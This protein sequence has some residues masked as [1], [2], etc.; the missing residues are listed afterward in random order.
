M[1]APAITVS[2]I[3]H[4]VVYVADVARSVAF[5][6]GVLGM[7]VRHQGKGYAFLH[8]G[9]A[10]QQIGLFEAEDGGPPTDADLNHLAFSVAAGDYAGLKG[11]LEASGVEVRGRR[12][13]P[14]CIYFDDPDGHTLQIVVPGRR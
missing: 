7:S 10:G 3:D 6:T 9:G 13:D 14:D 8:C 4:V 12:G 2:A 1:G 5:Y 11:A